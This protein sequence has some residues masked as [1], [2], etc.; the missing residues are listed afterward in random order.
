VCVCMLVVFVFLRPHSG[1]KHKPDAFGREVYTPHVIRLLT[2]F[3]TVRFVLL[4][5]RVGPFFYLVVRVCCRS[6]YKHQKRKR[7]SHWYMKRDAV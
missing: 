3:N 6:R 2:S 5:P 7:D 1:T 4:S